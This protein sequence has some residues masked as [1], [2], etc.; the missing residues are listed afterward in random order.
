MFGIVGQTKGGAV[1]LRSAQVTRRDGN[2]VTVLCGVRKVFVNVWHKNETKNIPLHVWYEKVHMEWLH[3][4]QAR[5]RKMVAVTFLIWPAFNDFFRFIW[6]GNQGGQHKCPSYSNADRMAGT[7]TV[8]RLPIRLPAK[9]AL[10][11]PVV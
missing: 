5:T 2:W 6:S 7:V 4:R 8:Y 1:C 11:W 9:S 3:E 10:T